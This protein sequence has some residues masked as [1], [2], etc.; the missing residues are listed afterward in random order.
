MFSKI[1]KTAAAALCVM[2]GPALADWS[3]SP[4]S[5]GADGSGATGQVDCAPNGAFGTIWGTGSYTSDS[6]VCTAA[7][8]YGWLN[9][10]Q[11]GQVTF[12]SVAGLDAYPG[13][14]QNG[15]NSLDYG[16]WGSS[17][18]ITGMTPLAGGSGPTVISWNQNPDTLGVGGSLGEILTYACPPDQSVGGTIWGTDVYTSD[19]SICGA[20]MHRGHVTQQQGGVV[21]ILILGSQPAFSGTS[22]NGVLSSD[23]PEWG[24]SYTF[25]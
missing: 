17:F 7:V 16:S 13:T 3:A 23:Y 18:Q 8:H 4:I 25:Q 11:G 1:C 20:A 21:S 6:S 5:L 24:R 22:R 10:A 14:A 19:S 12:R 15:V 9:H 2:S